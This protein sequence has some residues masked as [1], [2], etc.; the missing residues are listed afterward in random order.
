[1][2]ERARRS[3]GP[4]AVMLL[5]IDHFKAVNDRWGHGG[6]DRV[7]AGVALRLRAW[8]PEEALV[9]RIGG[10][11]FLVALPDTGA[12]EARAW[13]DGL[14]ARVRARPFPLDLPHGAEVR[15]TV[16]VGV[17]AAA[18]PHA[19]EASDLIARADAA[20]YRAK[21]AGRDAVSMAGGLS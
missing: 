6:G 1:M 12:A 13:A 7:L 8:L 21:N 19:A 3:G 2:V 16:S 17:A 4:L 10:E 5:D 14:R 9:A 11:E 15:V 20:L 18:G